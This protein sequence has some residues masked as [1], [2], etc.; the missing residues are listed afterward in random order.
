MAEVDVALESSVALSPSSQDVSAFWWHRSNTLALL[1]LALISIWLF[2]DHISGKR[3]FIGN[4]DRLNT[5]LNVVQHHVDSLRAGRLDAWSDRMFIGINTFG[6]PYIFPQPLL[7]LEALAPAGSFFYVAGLVA[8]MLL[9]LA[10][11]S[12][13][14]YLK[15]ITDHTWVSFVGA[16]L[17]Q[18]SAL[19]TL[20]VSQNEM[21]FAVLIVIPLM[22]LLIYTVKPGKEFK[23]L[24][25]LT[26]LL[27][28]MLT[29]MFLQKAAYALM[30][31]GP[32]PCTEQH[33]AQTGGPW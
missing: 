32:I 15:T 1:L 26:G 3:V 31:G 4:S 28:F 24:T 23:S 20:K 14:A 30:L 12:A 18:L 8:C 7:F 29:C 16:S 11:W 5:M 22:L 27:G 21:S 25:L 19:T 10:G 2:R 17:Y 13:F 9:A 6:L 33:A